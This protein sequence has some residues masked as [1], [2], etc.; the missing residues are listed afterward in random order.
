MPLMRVPSG[1]QLFEEWHQLNCSRCHWTWTCMYLGYFPLLVSTYVVCERLSVM[2][3]Q[4]SGWTVNFG[5]K[6]W[7]CPTLRTV[8]YPSPPPPPRKLKFRQILEL[9]VLTWLRVPPPQKKLKFRQILELW[10]LTWQSNPPPPWKF[11]YRQ[12]LEF[13]VLTWQS[14][15]PHPKNWNLG[16]SWNFEFWLGRVPPLPQNW[17]LGRSWNFEF[18]LGRVPPLKIEI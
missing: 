12:I 15:S 2:H 5:S 3:K 9:W 1:Q 18:W 6:F 7:E 10:V 17:N 11:K 8:E 4:V 13:W 14:T 16:R